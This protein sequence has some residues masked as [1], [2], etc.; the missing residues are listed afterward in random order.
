MKSHSPM[1]FRAENRDELLQLLGKTDIMGPLENDCRRRDATEP[2]AM[3][4]FLSSLADGDSVLK[5]PLELIHR[6]PPDDRPDF[7]LSMGGKEIGVEHVAARSEKEKRKDEL[8]R[9]EGIGPQVYTT[10]PDKPAKPD[11]LRP[12]TEDLRKEILKDAHTPGPGDDGN[13]RAWV[14]VM[15]HFIDKKRAKLQDPEFSQYDE[16]W[17]LIRDAWAF[18]S[19]NMENASRL[20]FLQIQDQN[21]KLG[22]HRV[23][24]IGS[25]N[26]APVSETTESGYNLH[27]RNDLWVK[28]TLF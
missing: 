23:F 4:H 20:L 1:N 17:L 15:L 9:Q 3:A 19:V 12:T 2:Y 27:P 18:V 5:F 21:I 25:L 13:D 22:F 26:S 7:L 16:D 24:I 6:E 14:K 8:R 28:R 11:E 10:T